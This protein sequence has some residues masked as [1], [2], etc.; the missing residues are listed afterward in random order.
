MVSNTTTMTENNDALAPEDVHHAT[1]DVRSKHAAASD[2]SL[3]AMIFTPRARAR[4]LDALVGAH[5]EALSAAQICERAD[6]GT[7]SFDRQKDALLDLGVLEEAGMV[8]N[9]QTYRLNRAHPV[10]QLLGMLDQVLRFGTTSM[11]LD[12]RFVGTPG[13]DYEPGEHPDDP[14]GAVED[15]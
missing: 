8:G 15:C 11:L 3:L 6:V 13:T 10:A 2:D 12:E 4:I 9:A 5:T 14:R 1:E 7:S